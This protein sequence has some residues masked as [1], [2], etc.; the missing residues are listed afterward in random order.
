[1]TCSGAPQETCGGPNRL[2][3]YSL[4]TA[5][6]SASPPA[7]TGW[8]F[9]GCYTD[10]VNARALIA[11]SVPN[12]PSSMTIEACQSVCKGLGYTLAGLEYAD[13]CCKSNSSSIF[14]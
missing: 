1:M 9:R 8:N 10:S 11:E 12:G 13:E 5:T 7:A 14:L 2:D 3:V 6:G 4:A